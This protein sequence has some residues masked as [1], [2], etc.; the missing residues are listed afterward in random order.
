[1]LDSCLLTLEDKRRVKD[2]TA[3]V[4]ELENQASGWVMGRRETVWKSLKRWMR[5]GKTSV[6]LECGGGDELKA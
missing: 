5:N 2:A 3:E 1:M 6:S 4:R